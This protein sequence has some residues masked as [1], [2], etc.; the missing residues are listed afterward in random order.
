LGDSPDSGGSQFFIT[1]VPTNGLDGK[2]TVFGRVIEG[3]SVLSRIARRDPEAAAG[4]GDTILK[5]T[6]IRKRD[7]KYEPTKVK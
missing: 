5:A 7:H 6:V 3:M 4:P 2:H 1:F